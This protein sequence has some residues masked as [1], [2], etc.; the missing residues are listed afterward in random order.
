MPNSTH[1]EILM[2]STAEDTDFLQ[3]GINQTLSRYGIPTKLAV[4]WNHHY[5]L[6]DNNGVVRLCISIYRQGL[7]RLPH[8]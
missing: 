5:Q 2:V 8:W 4:F 6:S 3:Q 1:H 7:K